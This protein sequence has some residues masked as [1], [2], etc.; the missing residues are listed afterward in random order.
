MGNWVLIVLLVA[1]AVGF[2]SFRQFGSVAKAQSPP[3]EAS[4]E[5][6]VR[7]IV[8]SG[9]V[10]ATV[11]ELIALAK[12]AGWNEF[13]LEKP[14]KLTLIPP[15]GYSPEMFGNLLQALEKSKHRNFGLQLLDSAGRAVDPDGKPIE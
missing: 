10:Q 6:R 5:G 7:L 14:N 3:T 8:N 15:H 2:V 9:D 4:Q 12:E 1:G 11:N 13:R